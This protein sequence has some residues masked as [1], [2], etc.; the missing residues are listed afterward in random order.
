MISDEVL[1]E[2][3]ISEADQVVEGFDRP[4]SGI[5]FALPVSH[6]LGI[7]K[8]GHSLPVEGDT[9]EP[10]NNFLIPGQRIEVSQINKIFDLVAVQVQARRVFAPG[11]RGNLE[12]P[13]RASC[14]RGEPRR[15]LDWIDR[16]CILG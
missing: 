7:R 15:A 16:Y 6:A 2:K 1:L 9:G 4:H 8:R 11:G 12:Q 5:L 10:G 3:A 13:A 14:V